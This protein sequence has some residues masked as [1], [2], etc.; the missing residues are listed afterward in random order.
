VGL[1][2]LSLIY[3]NICRVFFAAFAF[4]DYEDRRDAEVSVFDI[5]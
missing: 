2:Q 1:F 3:F 5:L 4:V